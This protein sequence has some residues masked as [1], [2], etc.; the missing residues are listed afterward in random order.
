MLEIVR[1]KIQP[2]Q[3]PDF[4][5]CCWVAHMWGAW[6]TGTFNSGIPLNTRSYLEAAAQC[7]MN[8]RAVMV[9][10]C[11]SLASER[12]KWVR[13]S[14]LY[15]K[16]FWWLIFFLM[17]ICLYHGSPC[18][19]PTVTKAGRAEAASLMAARMLQQEEINS[20]PWFNKTLPP[21]T[22]HRAADTSYFNSMYLLLTWSINR[23]IHTLLSDWYFPLFPVAF[24]ATNEKTLFWLGLY[25]SCTKCGRTNLGS[26]K[27]E[28]SD[29]S[30]SNL[31]YFFPF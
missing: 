1:S 16:M 22:D 19:P 2:F 11:L 27:L 26:H 4:W 28:G 31:I 25:Y 7:C 6:H 3:Q 12:W 13:L 14:S 29:W 9:W 20:R 24:R 18:H 30:S 15:F 17:N 23:A 10:P 5:G 8:R 21:L